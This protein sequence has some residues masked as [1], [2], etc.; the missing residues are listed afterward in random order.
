MGYIGWQLEDSS[1]ITLIDTI[2]HT[3]Y[4][5]DAYTPT[6]AGGLIFSGSLPTSLGA[7]PTLFSGSGTFGPTS[8]A[9]GFPT[10]G[11][12]GQGGEVPTSPPTPSPTWN[13]V[14]FCDEMPGYLDGLPFC[15]TPTATPSAAPAPTKEGPTKEGPSPSP[16]TKVKV[17]VKQCR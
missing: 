8:T 12:G 17:I 13:T 16:P 7:G 5:N 14:P 1:C 15:S 10:G 3:N 9:G 11:F 6:S 4:T 2:I